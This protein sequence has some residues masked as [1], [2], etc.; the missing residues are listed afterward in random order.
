MVVAAVSKLKRDQPML[1]KDFRLL[2]HDRT[3]PPDEWTDATG[4]ES[5]T[6]KFLTRG[7]LNT[8]IGKIQDEGWQV[9]YSTGPPRTDLLITDFG[10]EYW[11]FRRTTSD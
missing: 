4:G 3:M 11:L 5:F 1:S 7:H 10:L 2:T 8:F 9:I 6:R